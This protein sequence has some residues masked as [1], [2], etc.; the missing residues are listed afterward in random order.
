[1]AAQE[2]ESG[3]ALIVTLLL[4][5]IAAAFIGGLLYIVSAGTEASG[6]DTRHKSALQAVHSG[7]TYI[8]RSLLPG[9]QLMCSPQNSNEE[10]ACHDFE[11]EY[12]T[13]TG[14]E[15]DWTE[16]S[17]EVNLLID[18]EISDYEIEATLLDSHERIEQETMIEIFSFNV[19]AESTGLTGE[20]AEVEFVYKLEWED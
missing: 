16:D 19:V 8:Q 1:M 12:E 17:A 5:L 11:S 9:D 14:N 13:D 4:G 6:I 2:K 18:D 3:L 10:Y 20:R 15:W 7:A